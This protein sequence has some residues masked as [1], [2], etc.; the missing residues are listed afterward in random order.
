M[1]RAPF[2]PAVSP[3]PPVFMQ[4]HPLLAWIVTFGLA[5][6]G[7][8]NHHFLTPPGTVEQQRLRA[9]IHDPYA[10]P[11]A[12]PKIDGGRPRDYIDP[13]P[14]PVRNRIYADSFLRR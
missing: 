4:R 14:R 3:H 2:A 9:T 1:I 6:G 12:A 11:D 13:L 7:C 10:D 5:A 8:A